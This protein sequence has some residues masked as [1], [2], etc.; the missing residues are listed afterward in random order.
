M[1]GFSDLADFVKAVIHSD[2]DKPDSRLVVDES[3]WDG[4]VEEE[5][6]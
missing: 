1:D 3:L 6:I 2:S 4:A 5:D